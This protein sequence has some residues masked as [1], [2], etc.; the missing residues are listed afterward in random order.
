MNT[1]D[2]W[3]HQVYQSTFDMTLSALEDRREKDTKFNIQ[4]M[5]ALLETEYINQGNDWD[6]RGELFHLKQDATIAAY[7]HF[8][9]EWRKVENV[10]QPIFEPSPEIEE[11]L[12][13]KGARTLKDLGVQPG[14]KVLDI[15]CGI[16]SWCLPLTAAVGPA[17]KVIAID[18]SV[19]SIEAVRQL[20]DGTPKNLHL[21]RVEKTPDYPWI[22]D[23]SLDAVFVFD[24]LQHIDD[25]DKL[26]E[27]ITRV[28]KPAGRLY[29]NPS[30]MMH[31]GQ[32][33]VALF[34]EKTT[35]CGFQEIDQRKIDIMHYKKM[36][37]DRVYTLQYKA[38]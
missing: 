24:V 10:K 23:A 33:D 37:H 25:W 13:D 11:W 29:V 18:A 2:D 16:G 31:E 21:R 36:G 1:V 32:I 14:W 19:Q 4:Q 28:L 5:E 7:E 22:P 15:G 8:L 35:A 27:E 26:L 30:E 9:A 3:R 17:G 34:F 38:S 6:G 12:R 20:A